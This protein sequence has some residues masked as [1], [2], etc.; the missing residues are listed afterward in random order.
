MIKTKKMILSRIGN[1]RAIASK[2]YPFFPKHDIYI[3]PFFGAGGMFFHKPKA[4]HN[5]LNDLDED[6]YNLF[7][8][9]INKKD[10]FVDLLEKTP[11]H[12]ALFDHW[13]KNKESD[14]V[15][16]AVRFIVLS[17]F[18][19][20]GK[21]GTFRIGADLFKKQIFEK[22]DSTLKSFGDSKFTNFDFEK[23]I[24]TLSL[25]PNE[26]NRAFVY[27]DPPYVKT[28]DNYQNSFKL[29]DAKRLFDCL[30]KSGIKFAYS[31]FDN[32]DI[33]EIAKIRNL[34]IRRVCTRTALKNIK[35]EILITNY[36]QKNTLFD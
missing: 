10:E 14:P 8:V 27:A 25:K 20:L 35:T 21:G 33:I 17:N 29:A 7:L 5:F 30:I 31:E 2:I 13:A 1:K 36:N 26:K 34:N 28:T 3:E 32:P 12:K 15:M 24:N 4:S 9:S 6:V 16:A 19:Y 11:I 18:S 23:M 22:L